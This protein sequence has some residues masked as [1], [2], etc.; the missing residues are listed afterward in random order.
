MNDRFGASEVSIS[1][2]MRRIWHNFSFAV[3]VGR[4]TCYYRKD[5]RLEQNTMFSLW[6][7]IINAIASIQHQI[8][9]F[10]LLFSYVNKFF[11]CVFLFCFIYFS[12]DVGA[13]HAA[14]PIHFVDWE[15]K[16]I[17]IVGLWVTRWTNALDWMV[18]K[19]L[20]IYRSSYKVYRMPAPLN[21][22]FDFRILSLP[23]HSILYLIRFDNIIINIW[24]EW[25]SKVL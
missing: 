4:S 16:N 15:I 5:Q 25:I 24:S 14:M 9:N 12:Y 8:C 18:I 20:T 22:P 13:F 11:S 6:L 21:V 7:A 23:V 17:Q 19:L 2:G 1:H 10:Q 3:A